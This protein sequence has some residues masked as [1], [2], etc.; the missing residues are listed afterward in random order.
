LFSLKGIGRRTDCIGPYVTSNNGQKIP[1]Q[2]DLFQTAKVESLPN[3][4]NNALETNT[5]MKIS[6]E[7]TK[8]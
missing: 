2:A 3:V 8:L 7:K 4:I 5:N 6:I 1:D